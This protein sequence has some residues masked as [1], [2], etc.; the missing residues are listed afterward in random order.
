MRDNVM[1]LITNGTCVV[2]SWAL[3]FFS[4]FNF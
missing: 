3:H 4:S 1:A 2:Y